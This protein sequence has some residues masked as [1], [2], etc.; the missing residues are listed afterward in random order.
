M[1]QRCNLSTSAVRASVSA[2]KPPIQPTPI[3]PTS[4]CFTVAL[5]VV[6]G[7]AGRI[8]SMP[9][10]A[11]QAIRRLPAMRPA[12]TMVLKKTKISGCDREAL[13]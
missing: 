3:H 8:T 1:S 9:G 11:K 5:L 4:T 10:A 7:F 12:G 2:R 13:R 6:L